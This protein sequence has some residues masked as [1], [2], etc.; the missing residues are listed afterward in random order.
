MAKNDK[1][2]EE[3]ANLADDTVRSGTTTQTKPKIKGVQAA[4]DEI[5]ETES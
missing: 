2:K 5:T 4:G 1:P 3:A